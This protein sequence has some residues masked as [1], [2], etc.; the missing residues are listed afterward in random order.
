MFIHR[1]LYCLVKILHFSPSFFL[2]DFQ[3]DT[4]C[5]RISTIQP[6]AQTQT[7]AKRCRTAVRCSGQ[8]LIE[9][10]C[11]ELMRKGFAKISKI[12]KD[13]QIHK[14]SQTSYTARNQK[15]VRCRKSSLMPNETR[16]RKSSQMPNS[17]QML[18]TGRYQTQLDA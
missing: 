17:N 10:Q 18:K 1:L 12:S 14:S 8:S 7:D 2:V 9:N 15:A 11:K 3:S 16:C 4:W 5:V 6:G 13:S